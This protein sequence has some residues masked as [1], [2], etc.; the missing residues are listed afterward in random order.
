MFAAKRFEIARGRVLQDTQP[1][2][3]TGREDECECFARWPEAIGKASMAGWR[4]RGSAIRGGGSDSWKT[5]RTRGNKG[6]M[7]AKP[8]QCRYDRAMEMKTAGE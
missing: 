8:A 7:V 5:G 1:L 4:R 6:K 2:A 3:H